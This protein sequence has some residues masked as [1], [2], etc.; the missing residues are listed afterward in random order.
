MSALKNSLWNKNSL[1]CSGQTPFVTSVIFLQCTHMV[2]PSLYLLPHPIVSVPPWVSSSTFRNWLPPP[3]TQQTLTAT[4]Q[5]PDFAPHSGIS[6]RVQH[7]AVDSIR[8]G[9]D[10]HS[11]TAIERIASSHQVPA[12]LQSVLLRRVIFR[13]LGQERKQNIFVLL[14]CGSFCSSSLSKMHYQGALL[15]K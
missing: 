8:H 12:W 15:M 11:G 6:H 1:L 10:Q 7:E 2:H 13:N 14:Y 3:H 9:Q 5:A 4:S